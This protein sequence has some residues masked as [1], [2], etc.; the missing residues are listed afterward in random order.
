MYCKLLSNSLFLNKI[1]L[2]IIWVKEMNKFIPEV[3]QSNEMG[4]RRGQALGNEHFCAT[5]HWTKGWTQ[6]HNGM[7]HWFLVPRPLLETH[8]TLLI[9]ACL[10]ARGK[11]MFLPAA[12]TITFNFN[13]NR[14]RTT[15]SDWDRVVYPISF[16][17]IMKSLYC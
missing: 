17:P 4:W 12:S 16:K 10:S 9:S 14:T 7:V 3:L 8:T 11:S 1:N 6:H 15:K 5:S 13:D 2:K